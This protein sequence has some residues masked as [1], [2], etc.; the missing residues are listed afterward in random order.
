MVGHRGSRATHAEN[1]L[2]AFRYAAFCG[3]DAVELDV[4]L[5][6]DGVL[7]VRHDPVEGPFASL[8]ASVPRLEEVLKLA[9]ESD[10]VFDVEMKD[11]GALTRDA[12]RYAKMLAALIRAPGLA[13]RVMVRSFEHSYLRAFHALLPDVPLVALVEEP[14]DWVRICQSAD[15]MAISPR[16][17]H[18]NEA[19]VAGAHEAGLAV[20]PWTV[21]HP[22]DWLRMCR[23]RV[24]AIVTDDPAALRAWIDR[25]GPGL[26][27]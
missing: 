10:L 16:F 18:V 1:T 25:D 27:W 17:E 5:T 21:N 15:S 20:I 24:D 26:C 8:D 22:A 6:S 9:G 11:C 14:G 4:V 2:D 13:G 3:A 7:A 19:A 12:G 23:R